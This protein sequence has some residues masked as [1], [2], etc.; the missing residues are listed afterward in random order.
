MVQG[1]SDFI[2]TRRECPDFTK[3]Q[4]HPTPQKNRGAPNCGNENPKDSTL[5]HQGT[6]TICCQ[7]VT[8]LLWLKCLVL[9]VH[10]PQIIDS[11]FTHLSIVSL[12]IYFIFIF[13]YLIIICALMVLLAIVLVITILYAIAISVQLFNYVSLNTH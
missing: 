5:S 10:Y 12:C 2:K 4:S 9:C 11:V 13:Y 1:F 8:C 7:L 6:K 3:I